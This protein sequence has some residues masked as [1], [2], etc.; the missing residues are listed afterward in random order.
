MKK[1][2]SV[3][4][5]FFV[6]GLFSSA[7]TKTDL[8]ASLVS[9]YIWRGQDLGG[10]SIQ[11]SLTVSRSGFY[12]GAFGS[13][14][15]DENDKKELD[16][17]TGFKLERLTIGFTD[18]YATPTG[19]KYGNWNM[20]DGN[21][22]G[23]VGIGYDLRLLAVNA[24]VDVYGDKDYSPYVEASAPF[25]L[26]GVDFNAAAGVVPVKS[27]YYGTDGFSLTNVSLRANKSI[28]GIPL[29]GQIVLNPSADAAYFVAGITF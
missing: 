27:I 2:I 6:S 22:V 23:E 16:L 14:G 12:I 13:I 5:S 24:Y 18:Y 29:F 15:L 20:K 25:H 7:Q 17:Y 10:F 3:F 11:P 8:G 1:I 21:H 9:K 19:T 26:G 4:V 28:K